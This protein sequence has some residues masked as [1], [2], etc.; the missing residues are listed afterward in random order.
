MLLLFML[1]LG[2]AWGVGAAAASGAIQ[3]VNPVQPLKPLSV[4]RV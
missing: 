1:N 3:K 4:G 2:F